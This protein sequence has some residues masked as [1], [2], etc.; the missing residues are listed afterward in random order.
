M[1]GLL[2]HLIF[3]AALACFLG[4]A[5][6]ARPDAVNR[7]VAEQ[8][9]ALS[10]AIEN[11]DAAAAASL[12]TADARLS[13]PGIN[14]VLTGREA[15]QQFWQSALGGGLKGL[16]LSRSDLLGD[17][18]LRIETGGYAAFGANRSELGRG[19]YLFVWKQEGGAWKIS[20]DF[21]H[22]TSA[23]PA[24]MQSSGAAAGKSAPDRVGLPQN[25]TTRF[26]KLGATLHDPNHGLTTVY[27][28]DV[29]ASALDS[30]HYPNGSV[31]LMEF[32]EPQKDGE[33][34]LLRDARGE[35]IPG[36][37]AHIDVMRREAGY[38][39]SYGAS[40]AG[41][42]EFASYRSDGSTR[43]SAEQGASC[44]GCHLRAGAEKDFVFRTRS[45]SAH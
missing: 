27:A 25:Y 4:T 26:R 1:K 17:G 3:A 45:W 31:I 32:A 23:Q 43:T 8:S 22:P 37:I 38:G 35:L 11:G 6:A 9:R 16:E 14:N 13:V 10:D 42:W 33:D 21:A 18:H 5:G 29:A 12:F 39:A 41:E 15:I 20:H 40:R 7:A 34:Q 28:N 24:G 44:A 19:Q 36:P 2:E 30:S